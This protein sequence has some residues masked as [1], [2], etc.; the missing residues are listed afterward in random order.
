MF[1]GFPREG[2]DEGVLSAG[3]S[4]CVLGDLARD[5]RHGRCVDPSSPQHGRW[6]EIAVK[7]AHTE[8]DLLWSAAMNSSRA[9]E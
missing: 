2:T 1:S 8:G 6:L 4:L 5:A 3:A 7:Y 9:P